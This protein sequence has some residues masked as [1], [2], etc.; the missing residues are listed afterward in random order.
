MKKHINKLFAV[1]AVAL[2][3]ASC[4]DD[5]DLTTLSTVNFAGGIEASST[6]IVIDADNNFQTVTTLSWQ[7]VAFPVNAPVTYALEIDIPTDTLGANAWANAQRIEVGEAVLSKSFLGK[8]LNTIALAL[9]LQYDTPG[10][11]AVRAIATLDR[12]VYSKSIV[13][14]V[15]PFE[16][17]MYM[18]GQYQGWN[19][20]TAARLRGI[21]EGI[22]QGY[23]TFPEGQLEFKFTPKKNWDTF[24]G[25][26]GG[27]G[28][29]ENDDDNL[30]VPAAGTY[31]ITVNL[32]TLTYSAVP[33]AYGIIGTAT[34]GGWDADTNMSYDHVAE[35][36]T[37]TG[38]LTP[39]AL[40]F[41]LNDAW[42]INYGSA[43]GESGELANGTVVLD[44]S[45]AH[46][47]EESGNYT[48]TFAV[49]TPP[50]TATYTVIKN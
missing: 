27:D 4:T 37:Y 5:G 6:T 49:D 3:G 41:R 20:E 46:T 14:N 11:L 40:K 38:D 19:P 44:N 24:Y 47:I 12:A 35:R 16:L 50:A 48:V 43:N 17:M 34:P 42:T 1:F 26:T 7:D 31:Q 25:S 15:T 13:L 29:A 45:G 23:A 9:G 8:D 21:E 28:I 30:S 33:Y 36:W 22:F 32:N 18:P 2:L 39:G 10:Q